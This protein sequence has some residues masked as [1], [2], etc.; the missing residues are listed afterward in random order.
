MM[1]WKSTIGLAITKGKR[2]VKDDEA[3]PNGW[4]TAEER[5]PNIPAGWKRLT[6]Q[7][8]KQI[9]KEIYH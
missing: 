1:I 8:C 5:L 4:K 7:S 2:E 9:L 6:R 3:V